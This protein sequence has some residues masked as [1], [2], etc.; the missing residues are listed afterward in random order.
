MAE[1]KKTRKRNITPADI[2]A[3]ERLRVIWTRVKKNKKITEDMAAE[4]FKITQGA[5]NQYLHGK[6]AL[7]VVATLRFARFL[8]CNPRDIRPDLGDLG[9]EPSDLS[10]EAIDLALHWQEITQPEVREAAAAF[11]YSFS[12]QKIA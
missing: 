6:I 3:A 11:I 9:I 4:K 5:V 8:E 1:A 12:K 10:I 7:G 2:A